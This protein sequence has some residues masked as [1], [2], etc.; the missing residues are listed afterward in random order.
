MQRKRVGLS[1]RPG[2]CYARNHIEKHVE[3]R[4]LIVCYILSKWD[5][6][7]LSLKVAICYVTMWDK[8]V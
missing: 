5:R 4:F 7:Q 1:C 3:E 6:K 8:W 2:R